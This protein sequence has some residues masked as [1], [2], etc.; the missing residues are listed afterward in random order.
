MTN[1]IEHITVVGGGTAG[2]MTAT[3]LNRF[4]NA[5]RDGPGVKVTV[6]ESPDIPTVGVGE[7]TVAGMSMLLNQLGVDEAEFM[8]RCNASFKLAV[9]FNN[10]ALDGAG[11]PTSYLHPFN[12]PDFLNGVCPAYH[13]N[14]FG[15]HQGC[16]NLAD[17]LVPNTALIDA[18]KGPRYLDGKNYEH[19]INYAYHLDAGLFGRFLRDVGVSQGIQHIQDDV[20]E[21]AQDERG[22]IRELNLKRRGAFPVEFVVDCTGFKGLILQQV[23]GE[24]FEPLGETLL[25]DRAIPVQ[26]PHRNPTRL[27]PCTSS[28][29][30]GAGWVWRVPLYS[31][32][33]TGY[34]FSSAFRTDDEARDEFFRH[35][36]GIGD[37]PADAP[38]PE[39]RVIHM[40]TGRAQ[41]AWVKNCVAIG[42][43]SGFVEPLES[44]AIYMIEMAGRWLVSHLPDREV[45]PVFADR[46]NTLMSSLFDEVKDFI[47]SHYR[48]SNRG[49]PFWLAARNDIKMPESLEK[50]LALWQHVLPD[51]PDTDG[52]KLFNFWNYIYTLW[53]K[54]YFVGKEF[55]LEGS[56]ARR[57]WDAFGRHLTNI[58]GRLTST[59]PDHYQLL[60]R[61]REGASATSAAFEPPPELKRRAETRATVP[62]S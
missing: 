4:L 45:N 46:Y 24:S 22:F 30:L 29:A 56:I 18:C 58:R 48:T 32:L 61:I 43:S 23:L 3:I 42:L 11:R 14:K 28:S 15:P 40:K 16:T 54:G 44:T 33:G 21:I 7:A 31:R 12:Y 50:S 37:L 49:D 59:L 52:D 41:R 34:V 13:F 47:V 1:R 38:D 53:P 6:I 55:P 51:V 2:W 25:C 57:D 26:L 17:S 20:T 19:E 27:E 5:V 36:R 62:I 10:W 9:R 8:R 35:L 39:T 60:T